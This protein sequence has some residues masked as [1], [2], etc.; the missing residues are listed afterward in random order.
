MEDANF[1]EKTANA[2]ILRVHTLLGWCEDVVK[3]EASLRRGPR[4]YH[5]EVFEHEINELINVTQS[6][7][8]A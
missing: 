5:D 4:G 6:H 8:E 2:N 7:Y 3:E 1:E